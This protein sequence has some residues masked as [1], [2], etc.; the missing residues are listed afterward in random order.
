MVGRM[1]IAFTRKDP[2]ATSIINEGIKAQVRPSVATTNPTNRNTECQP[3]SL[4]KERNLNKV[5]TINHPFGKF[6]PTFIEKY[7]KGDK[8]YINVNPMSIKMV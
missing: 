5:K 3:F 7:N 1:S 4:G 8:K 6:L 2:A